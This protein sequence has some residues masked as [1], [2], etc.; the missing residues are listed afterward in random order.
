MSKKQ[1]TIYTNTHFKEATRLDRIYMA[2]IEPERFEG[3]LSFE[4]QAYLDKLQLAYHGCFNELRHS[5]AI[6]YIQKNIRDCESMYKANRLL[7]DMQALYGRFL[8]KNKLLKQAIV[9]ERMY[10]AA[11]RMQEYAKELYQP[12]RD[13]DGNPL[14]ANKDL[15]I[16]VEEKAMLMLEKAAKMDGLDKLQTGFDPKEFQLP[17]VEVTSDPAV[18]REGKDEEE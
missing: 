12:G 1:L 4:E 11:E 16:A 9:V 15:A 3:L 18:L 10:E 6:F 14:P 5:A 2:M 17:E 13:E 8:L 7:E